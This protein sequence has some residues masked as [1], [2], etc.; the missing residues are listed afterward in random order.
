MTRSTVN[1]QQFV[2]YSSG[3]LP[4][5]LPEMVS[6]YE[7][8]FQKVMTPCICLTLQSWGQWFALCPPLS[9]GFKKSY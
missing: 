5:P 7:L 8:V 6:T 9:Y 2:N 1:L 3:F 4:S